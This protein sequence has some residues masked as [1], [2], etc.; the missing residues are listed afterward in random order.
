MARGGAFLAWRNGRSTEI[1]KQ[2]IS[3]YGARGYG[4]RRSGGAAR[5]KS[6]SVKPLINRFG[7]LFVLMRNDK[8]AG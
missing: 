3:T 8:L 5:Q 7:K 1:N 6:L 4:R 2:K